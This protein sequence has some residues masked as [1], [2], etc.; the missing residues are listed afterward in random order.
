MSTSENLEKSPNT[1]TGADKDNDY[2]YNYSKCPSQECQRATKKIFNHKEETNKCYHIR[3]EADSK[4][5]HK[6][7][8]LFS[9]IN[10]YIDIKKSAILTLIISFFGIIL[11]L[12]PLAFVII[13][14]VIEISGGIYL[15]L[16]AR[17]N[18]FL[19]EKRK[20]PFRQRISVFI[21]SSENWPFFALILSGILYLVWPSVLTS[22]LMTFFLAVVIM[23]IMWYAMQIL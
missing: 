4:I 1:V 14:L 5:S 20:I 12:S 18:V 19:E 21:K 16:Q 10:S 2:G 9:D 11:Y 6:S 7:A 23:I 8:S 15:L 22:G 13:I 3:Q 17:D